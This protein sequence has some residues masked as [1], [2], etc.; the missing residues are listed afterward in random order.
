MKARKRKIH[1][2]TGAD[3]YELSAY[4]VRHQGVIPSDVVFHVSQCLAF[5]VQ[6]SDATLLS[7]RVKVPR[8]KFA[9][10]KLK[11]ALKMLDEVFEVD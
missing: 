1:V 11:A 3:S 7:E 9:L 6:G 10:R 5:L 2:A 4:C 8:N